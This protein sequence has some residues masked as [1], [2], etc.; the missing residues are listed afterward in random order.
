LTSI[1]SNGKVQRHFAVTYQRNI[2]VISSQLHPASQKAVVLFF[3]AK[4]SEPHPETQK[5]LHG[6]ESA[7]EA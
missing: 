4:R 2:N 3:F 5:R 1:G 7:V 6:V